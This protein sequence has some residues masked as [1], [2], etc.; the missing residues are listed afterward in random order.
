MVPPW[1]VGNIHIADCGPSTVWA[2]LCLI[3]VSRIEA[4][5]VGQLL[6]DTVASCINATPIYEGLR[7]PQ[8]YTGA[9]S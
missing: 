5:P 6:L 7:L 1:V 9:A 4:R 8:A 3:A 2:P